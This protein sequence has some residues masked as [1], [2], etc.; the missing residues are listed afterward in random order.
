MIL[1]VVATAMEAPPL[2]D[3]RNRAE[4]LIAGVGVLETALR[5]TKRLTAG[6]E[7]VSLVIN[8]GVGGGYPDSGATL[9]DICLA[10]H[11]VLGDLGICYGE[12]VEP[13]HASLTGPLTYP[14]SA[15]HTKQAAAILGRHGMASRSGVF[16]TVSA[17]SATTRRGAWLHR[18]HNGLCEN[19]EGAAVA[20]VCQEFGIPCI[21][22]RSISNLVEDRNPTTWQLAPAIRRCGQAVTLL[23]NSLSAEETP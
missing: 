23:V 3:C 22:V 19:M 13:L 6:Q 15:S 7:P 9:L 4:V 5:L 14:L 20:R 2:A 17:V 1:L 21:E 8:C 16:V 11:E 18:A 10:E 12:Q